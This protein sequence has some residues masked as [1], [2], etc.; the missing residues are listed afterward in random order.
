[1]IA[2]GNI[3]T[4]EHVID[5]AQEIEV[6]FPG[7]QQ[8]IGHVVASSLTLD[9]AV[10]R[11]TVANPPPPLMWNDGKLLAGQ[12]SFAVGYP[13]Q[14]GTF[15]P[16]IVT[17]GGVS[18]TFTDSGEVWVQT[19]ASVNGGNSGGPLLDECGRVLGV[20]TLKET[21]AEG[22]GY[23]QATS[24]VEPEVENLA[25]SPSAPA[26]DS[27]SCRPSSSAPDCPVTGVWEMT[28]T[29]TY[30]DGTGQSFQFE[31]TI[32]QSGQQISG[33]TGSLT[34]TGTRSGTVITVQFTRPGGTGY[35][36]WTLQPDGTLEGGY[37]DAGAKN[38]GTSAGTWLRDVPHE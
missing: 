3:V 28:D 27:T 2:G 20:V 22:I 11:A 19:D 34:F 17:K 9:V 24:S 21:D 25:G 10:I 26:P 13:A 15:G 5:Q 32:D 8:A 30:G 37:A 36:S 1:M 16:P 23:A 4:A 35:F 31:M 18:R 14:A 6:Q 7:G 38:G 33:Y 12:T 29:V